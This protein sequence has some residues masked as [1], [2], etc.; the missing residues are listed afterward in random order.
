MKLINILHERINCNNHW[1]TKKKPIF[2]LFLQVAESFF[3]KFQI[4]L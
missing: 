1:N 4:F 2:N 3:N